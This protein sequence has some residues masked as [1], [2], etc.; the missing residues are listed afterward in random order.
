MSRLSSPPRAPDPGQVELARALDALRP[1]PERITAL[2]DEIHA[3]LLRESP[4]VRLGNFT[5]IGDDDL[6]RLF[7]AYDA[8]FF[9][10]Q[11]RRAVD[12]QAGGRLTFRVSRRLTRCGGTTTQYR[13]RRVVNGASQASTRYEIAVSSTLLFQT[14]ADLDRTVKVSGV[15]C[16]DRLQALQRIFEHEMLH[17]AEMLAWNR[18]FCSKPR[19]KALAGNIF[20]HTD[21]KHDLVTQPERAATQFKIR[22]GDQV[23]FQIEGQTH[24]GIVNRITRRATVLVE[25]PLGTPYT[26]GKRYRKFYVPLG[27]L[28]QAFV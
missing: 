6:R 11:L 26:D 16:H 17:L 13:Q 19:F 5:R 7:E 27:L 20:G 1:A 28:R 18:S 3:R 8:A 23:A 14:F 4:H 10:G 22:V 25:S 24:L 21:V 12:H 9:A 15:E 2:T